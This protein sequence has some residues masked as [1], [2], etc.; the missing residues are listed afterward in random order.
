MREKRNT[1]SD[2]AKTKGARAP[3]ATLIAVHRLVSVSEL[4]LKILNEIISSTSARLM[5]SFHREIGLT[6]A[7]PRALITLE[8]FCCTL[9]SIGGQAQ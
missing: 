4:K 9:R 3:C 2:S 7:M 1:W 8:K 5:C 6:A